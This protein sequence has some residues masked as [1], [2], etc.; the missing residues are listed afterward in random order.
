MGDEQLPTAGVVEDDACQEL[1]TDGAFFTPCPLC[2]PDTEP[3]RISV[4]A[5]Y[6]V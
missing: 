3:R 4:S 6:L 2:R 1:A 5:V